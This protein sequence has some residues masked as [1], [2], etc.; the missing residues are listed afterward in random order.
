MSAFGDY[1][2]FDA[3]EEDNCVKE[4]EK[5]ED[6]IVSNLQVKLLIN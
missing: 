5:L 2:F 3:F 1:D 6:Y 4:S